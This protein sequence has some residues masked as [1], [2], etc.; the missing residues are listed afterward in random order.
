MSTRAT[1]A[2]ISSLA[3]FAT[4][5]ISD[6]LL[7]LGVPTGGLIPDLSA[8]SEK[9]GGGRMIGEAYTVKMVEQKEVDAPKLQEHFIDTAPSGSIMVI[10]SPPG[11]KSASLGGLLA[12][13]AAKRG[14]QGVVIAGRCRD[15]AEIRSLG[16]PVY[17]RGHSTLGQSPF[18][19]P[20]EI[21]IPLSIAPIGPT[22]FPPSEVH[23][24]DLVVGDEDGVVVVRPEM[25][26]QVLKVA[27]EGKEVDEK[28]RVAMEGGMGVKEAF[29]KY[30]G[31]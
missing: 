27:K 9:L 15:L 1:A 28:C 19:R 8:M 25:V 23:P 4:C 11:V 16:L 31:K 6:A 21:Q 29:K 3:E 17:S 30:R 5:E 10:S 14:V 7:K 2:Q 12:L 13:S 22:D 24:Y 26:D 18:T 20:S